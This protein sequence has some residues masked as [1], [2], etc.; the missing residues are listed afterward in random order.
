VQHRVLDER[1]QQQRRDA[2]VEKARV[3]DVDLGAEAIAEANLLQ[4]EV[5]ADERELLADGDYVA[6]D[7]QRAREELAQFADRR[8]RRGRIGV[9]ERREGV[10]R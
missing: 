4:I 5:V 8:A 1:L 7:V 6:I 2:C 3:G 9:D 10:A